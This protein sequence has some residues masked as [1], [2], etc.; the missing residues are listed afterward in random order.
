MSREE[1]K[2]FMKIKCLVCFNTNSDNTDSFDML[3]QQRIFHA[4]VDNFLDVNAIYQ[5]QSITN[6]KLVLLT[7][8]R[9]LFVVDHRVRK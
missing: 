4:S 6:L 1:K 7:L 9:R 3:W 2:S 8:S 5:K